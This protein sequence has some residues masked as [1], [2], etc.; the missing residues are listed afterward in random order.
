MAQVSVSEYRSDY[1]GSYDAA[2][3][4]RRIRAEERAIGAM[5]DREI[6]QQM[7]KDTAEIRR[8]MRKRYQIEI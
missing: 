6:A 3:Q 2:S 7:E 5:S 1:Y 8:T 4:R